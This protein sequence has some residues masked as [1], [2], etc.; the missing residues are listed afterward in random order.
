M[1]KS[2]KQ[3]T[4]EE[5]TSLLVTLETRFKKFVDRHPTLQWE[6]VQQKLEANEEKMWS[7]YQM[8]Q[9][10]GEPDVIA[11]DATTDEY[12][13]CD[14][15][16]ES[17]KGRRSICYDHVALEARKQNKPAHSALGMAE[18]M[19]IDILTEEQYRTLQQVGK[20]DTKTSS[21]LETPGSIRKL[22]GAIFGDYRY[23]QIFIYHNGADSYY[24]A[25]GF[26]GALR[27]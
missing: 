3:L 5:R 7:L 27:V 25:R 23:G 6:N 24:G 26:R 4:N 1:G 22:G 16:P 13:F 20:F 2:S 11:Y 10:E 9:T 17:P 12:I 19:G 15:S 14:C 8:E 18:E 21:W